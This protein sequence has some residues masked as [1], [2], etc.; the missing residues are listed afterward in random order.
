MAHEPGFDP[1]SQAR[2][3]GFGAGPGWVRDDCLR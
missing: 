2:M 1:Q 3:F